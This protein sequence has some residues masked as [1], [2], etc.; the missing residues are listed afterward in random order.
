MHGDGGT[1]PKHSRNQFTGDVAW[2]ALIRKVV[3]P[4]IRVAVDPGH[5][6]TL[7]LRST[8]DVLGDHIDTGMTR[9][10]D[11]LPRPD[12]CRSESGMNALGNVQNETTRLNVDIVL[13][14]SQPLCYG[15]Y[16]AAYNEK[17]IVV[18]RAPHFNEYAW[19]AAFSCAP[20]SMVELLATVNLGNQTD[21]AGA[22]GSPNNHRQTKGLGVFP[23]G[24]PL[25]RIEGA[26]FETRN[27]RIA[28]NLP[29]PLGIVR[30]VSRNRARQIWHGPV[31]EDRLRG[32]RQ[33][34][35]TRAKSLNSQI[36]RM[37]SLAN[38]KHLRRNVSREGFSVGGPI[39][40]GRHL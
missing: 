13:R 26:P 5:G 6:P 20:P 14:L 12:S 30:G 9:I 10:K 28:Q 8:R 36:A 38:Q 21:A 16:C 27:P 35:D 2:L 39:I 34:G 22:R 32:I 15:N 7:R 25:T 11:G 23:S 18:I 24:L 1:L 3:H 17:P 31:K 33:T 40:G 29:G 4:E 37:S 19:G